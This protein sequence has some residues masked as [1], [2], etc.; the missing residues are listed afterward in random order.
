MQ[1]YRVPEDHRIELPG[2]QWL[3]VK[4]YLTAGE[5]R[6]VMAHM[7]KRV[8][9]G[10]AMEL[11]P[12]HIQ[13]AQCIAYL[14]DW[15]IPDAAGH[16]VVIRD[17]PYDVVAAALNN[18]QSAAFQIIREAIEAHAA[19]MAAEL[20]YEKNAAGASAPSPTSASVA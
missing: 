3:L 13:V 16:P 14:I 17:R 7:L 2:G 20:E 5:E 6:E 18:M 9:A 8:I 11:D 10:Q 15:S 1:W 12:R 4:K 19:A